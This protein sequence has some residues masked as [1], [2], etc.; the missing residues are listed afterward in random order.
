MRRLYN[1]SLILMAL[2]ALPQQSLAEGARQGRYSIIEDPKDQRPNAV[3]RPANDADRAWRKGRRSPEIVNAPSSG[4][5][6]VR[7]FEAPRY[8]AH[9]RRLNV[10]GRPDTYDQFGRSGATR[11]P[12]IA[13]SGPQIRTDAPS[14]INQL[15]R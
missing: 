3:T 11:R 12:V 14:R 2:A 6:A 7:P 15:G 4:N 1:V 5:G 10:P 13:P 8:D 9:G